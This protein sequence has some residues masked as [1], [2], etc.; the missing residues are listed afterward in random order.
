M[1]HSIGKQLDD[2]GL[3]QDLYLEENDRVVA[4]TVELTMMRAPGQYASYGKEC[5]SSPE[6]GRYPVPFPLETR[7]VTVVREG[8]NL[9]D[10]QRMRVKEWLRANDIDPSRVAGDAPLTIQYRGANKGLICY[11]EYYIR[12][13]GQHEVDLLTRDGALKFQRAVPQRTPLPPEPQAGE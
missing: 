8:A 2:L 5:L 13:D 6:A 12:P 11:F 3:G 4:A 7:I 9:T 10:E 1:S